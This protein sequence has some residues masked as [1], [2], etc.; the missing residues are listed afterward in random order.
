MRERMARAHAAAPPASEPEPIPAPEPE[1]LPA[2]P[3]PEALPE[4]EPDPFP[5]GQRMPSW[6]QVEDQ[7][8]PGDWCGCCGRFKRSAGRWWREATEPR[9][10]RCRTCHPPDHLPAAAVVAVATG[11]G[12]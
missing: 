9:G 4:A 8:Q 1:P 10:W 7:P 5:M 6:A 11:R 12:G 2:V 3:L